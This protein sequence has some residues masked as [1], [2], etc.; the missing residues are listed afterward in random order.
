MAIRRPSRRPRRTAR[1]SWCSGFGRRAPDRRSV[2][3]GPFRW[4]EIV[5]ETHAAARAHWQSI[6]FSGPELPL[7][8][9]VVCGSVETERQWLDDRGAFD[10]AARINPEIDDDLSGDARSPRH[11]RIRRDLRGYRAADQLLRRQGNRIATT[12]RGQVL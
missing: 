9:A 7:Q 6:T 11:R 8:D 2:L 5:L 4:R 1:R 3:L 10:G 12:L